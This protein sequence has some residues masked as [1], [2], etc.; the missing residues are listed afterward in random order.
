MKVISYS[1]FGNTNSFEFPF[2]LR[3]VYFNARMN[4]L[5]YPDW[6]TVLFV[7][8]KIDLEYSAFFDLLAAKYGLS[9]ETIPSPLAEKGRNMLWRLLPLW[10]QDTEVLICRDLDSVTTW[11]EASAV[12]YWLSAPNAMHSIS[13]DVAHS[14]PMMGGMVGFKVKKV[15]ALYSEYTSFEKLLSVRPKLADHG[16]DQMLLMKA[17]YQ[18]AGD[19]L[20]VHS[21]KK[22]NIN[23]LYQTTA[24]EKPVESSVLWESDLTS[25]MIGSPGVVD[26]ELLRFFQRH[27]K[28]SDIDKLL[29]KL[30]ITTLKHL[31]WL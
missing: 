10:D 16:S 13:D 1:L 14:L 17:F 12:K 8:D 15:R 27:D 22:A 2:Y 9:T 23:H 29:R 5:L 26:F 24:T 21:F 25:R 11:R 30:P 19:N 20:L 18:K 6:H 31:Y 7:S 28:A 3:G 4:R